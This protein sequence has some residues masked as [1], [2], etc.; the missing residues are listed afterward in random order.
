MGGTTS[1][2]VALLNEQ[3]RTGQT[4]ARIDPTLSPKSPPVTL[5]PGETEGFRAIFKL[6]RKTG[7]PQRFKPDDRVPAVALK[8]TPDVVTEK[9]APELKGTNILIDQNGALVIA[10]GADNSV[11]LIVE[12]A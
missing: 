9:L 3:G 6:V 4:L 12:P 1:G 10:A 7:T 5:T 2:V 8:P 11:M